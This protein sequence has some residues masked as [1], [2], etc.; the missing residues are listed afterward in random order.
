MR[1]DF[2]YS[3][4]D[5]LGWN[6]KNNYDM[7][8]NAPRLSYALKIDIGVFISVEKAL[9][10]PNLSRKHHSSDTLETH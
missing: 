9:D 7:G 8:R 1:R 10:L 3:L 2:F 4:R 5:V 6:K